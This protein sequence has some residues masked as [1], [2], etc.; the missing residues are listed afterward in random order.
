MFFVLLPIS[1]YY[2]FFYDINI[3]GN[4][5]FLGF[6]GKPKE[7]SLGVRQTLTQTPKI[8]MVSISA[9][10]LHMSTRLYSLLIDLFSWLLTLRKIAIIWMS[11]KMS[12]TWHLKKKIAKNFHLKKNCQ[13]FLFFQKIG[14]GNFLKKMSSFGNFL[15]VKWQ[16]SGGSA[17]N[18]WIAGLCST[19]ITLYVLL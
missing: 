6:L 17:T 13:N 14:N 11:K 4:F 9:H 16:F 8:Y 5:A 2:I 7:L 12:K 10:T 1:K 3:G 15:T 19:N 18:Y